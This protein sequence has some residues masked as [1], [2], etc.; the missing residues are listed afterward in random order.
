MQYAPTLLSKA[1]NRYN[2]NSF[3]KKEGFL[4]LL[5]N[6]KIYKEKIKKGGIV[7]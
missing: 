2:K 4:N 6:L 5:S 1:I 7:K 3:S